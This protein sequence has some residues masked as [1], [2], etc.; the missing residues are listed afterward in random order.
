MSKPVSDLFD[1]RDVATLKRAAI[2][3]DQATGT[4]VTMEALDRLVTRLIERRGGP[5]P[6]EAARRKVNEE[7]EP[8]AG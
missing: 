4:D 5:L 8:D 6:E 3:F 2:A 7:R 1:L